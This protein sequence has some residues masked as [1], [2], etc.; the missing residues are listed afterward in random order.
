[1]KQTSYFLFKTSLGWCGIAWR[2]RP[3]D[4]DSYTVTSFQLPEATMQTTKARIA[5]SSG[6]PKPARPPMQIMKVVSKVCLHLNGLVQ[7]FRDVPVELEGADLF[8]QRVYAAVREIPAGST[9]T[10]GEIARTRGMRGFHNQT[11]V[12]LSIG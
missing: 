3:H 9:A 1:M 10:Y 4:A 7:D 12:V 11:L 8:S 5:Q 6:L 2:E